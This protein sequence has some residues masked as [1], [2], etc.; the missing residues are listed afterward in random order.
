M[1]PSLQAKLLRV[2]QDK[3]VRRLGSKTETPL[4]CRIISATNV[5]P[6][7]DAKIRNDL[8]YRLST[9]TLMLPPLRDRKEDIHVLSVFFLKKYN[10]RFGLFANSVSP[11][12]QKLFLQ[13]YWPG[14]VRELENTIESCMNF[15]ERDEKEIGMHHLP[16]YLR[17]K[18]L[19]NTAHEKKETAIEGKTLR[20]LLYNYE[21]KVI[22]EAL[23]RNNGNVSKTAQEL[24]VLRQ[25]LHYRMRRFN[26][27]IQRK[28][29]DNYLS[30]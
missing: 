12:L 7:T 11:E 18:F 15:L 27:Q 23:K 26:I 6:F 16:D 8:L 19:E 24:G 9:V 4:D 20:Y 13:Y 10:E 2:L 21:K 22:E 30:Q 3:M 5:D 25:N 29:S 28:Q 14:N 1:P 17:R